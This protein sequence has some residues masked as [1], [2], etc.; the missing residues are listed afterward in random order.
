MSLMASSNGLWCLFHLKEFLLIIKL[1]AFDVQDFIQ[2]EVPDAT[3]Y[4][5]LV[6]SHG[7]SDISLHVKN[8]LDLQSCFAES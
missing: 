8:L 4:G 7:R 2:P 5:S 1:L 6:K 3:N